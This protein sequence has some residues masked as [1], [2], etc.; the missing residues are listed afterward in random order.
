[1]KREAE[2]TAPVYSMELL[3]DA[4][5]VSVRSGEAILSAKAPKD[6]RIEF[7]EQVGIELKAENCHFF[8]AKTGVRID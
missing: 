5:Q 6:F 3:G 2:I 8:D 4:T 1:M 7:G